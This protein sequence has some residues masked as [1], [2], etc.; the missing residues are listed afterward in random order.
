MKQSHAVIQSYIITPMD[1]TAQALAWALGKFTR[2]TGL[3]AF[4]YPTH[5]SFWDAWTEVWHSGGKSLTIR[6]GRL[7]L[8][9]DWGA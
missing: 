7:E 6:L 9:A 5:P 1:H 3:G 2:V 8:I 4:W